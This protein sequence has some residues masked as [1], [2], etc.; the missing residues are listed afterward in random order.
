MCFYFNSLSICPSFLSYTIKS[1]SCLCNLIKKIYFF[2]YYIS[3]QH[4]IV[5][6]MHYSSISY[7][8]HINCTSELNKW[9]NTS[10]R[11]FTSELTWPQFVE[12][13]GLF[14]IYHHANKGI[15]S[16]A[17]HHHFL[18]VPAMKLC[19]HIK[20]IIHDLRMH[21]PVWQQ[22]SNDITDSKME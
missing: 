16:D 17:I 2:T 8:L 20:C 13:I 21:S 14:K 5:L 10:S 22:T 3:K 19:T 7:H 6:K 15:K 12:K 1:I 4:K 18:F 11:K 9:L